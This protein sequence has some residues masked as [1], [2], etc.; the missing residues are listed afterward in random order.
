MSFSPDVA[1]QALLDSSRHCC[2]CHRFCGVK[3]E[4]HHIVQRAE[5]GADT[6]D[7]C[8]PL[9]FDCHAEVKM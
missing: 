5:D 1:E 7:N 8:I 3:I 9:C 6:Y 2:L 4:L